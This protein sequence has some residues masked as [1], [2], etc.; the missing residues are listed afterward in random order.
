ME[1]GAVQV[2]YSIVSSVPL[3]LWPP[4][5]DEDARVVELGEVRLEGEEQEREPQDGHGVALEK[6]AKS[7]SRTGQ[8][9]ADCT[10]KIRSGFS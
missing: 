1:G 10:S 7:Q 5:V 6:R 2:Y 4:R 9:H 3:D 8:P